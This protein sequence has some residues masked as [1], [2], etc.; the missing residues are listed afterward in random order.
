MNLKATILSPHFDDA[1]YG[2]TLTISRL[3]NRNVPIKLL[4]CFTVTK[5]TAIPVES[6][7]IEA[8]SRLR[9]REDA[10]FNRL[11]GSVIQLVNLDLLDAPLRKGYIFQEKPLEAD[12]WEVVNELKLKLEEHLDG[13]LFCPLGIGSHIDHA[14]CLEAV[15]K[16]YPDIRVVFYE[17]LPYAA[18]ISFED[19]TERIRELEERLGV[20]LVNKLNLMSNCTI[21]KEQA[22]RVYESQMNEQICSE[23]VAHMMDLKGERLWGESNTIAMLSDM[24]EY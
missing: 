10:D 3:V 9:A 17:D 4:N 21:D 23:I 7:E 12:E 15:L 6:K 11:F 8:V 20:S 22:V 2:L 13:I 16:L 24:L 14:I 19:I 1:A 18:R 5:W